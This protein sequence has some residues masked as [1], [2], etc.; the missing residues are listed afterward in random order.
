MRARQLKSWLQEMVVHMARA[1]TSSHR[2]TSK[3]SSRVSHDLQSLLEPRRAP[4]RAHQRHATPAHTILRRE[5]LTARQ[6]VPAASL[7][8]TC[9]CQRR[10]KRWVHL[11]QSFNTSNTRRQV[12]RRRSRNEAQRRAKRR[13]LTLTEKKEFLVQVTWSGAK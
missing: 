9:L 5:G 3:Q 13:K 11:P 4:Q 6:E 8:T 10:S 1:P 2:R 7:Q 12:D